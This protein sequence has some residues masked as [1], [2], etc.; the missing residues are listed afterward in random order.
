MKGTITDIEGNGEAGSAKVSYKTDGLYNVTVTLSNPHGSDSKTYSY[1]QI[2][3][4]TGIA[5]VT[6]DELRAY[7]VGDVVYLEFAAAG[8]YNVQ[9][10]NIAGQLV[11]AKAAELT[12]SDRMQVR[13]PMVGAYVLRVFRDGKE[14]KALKLLR[15]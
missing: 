13:L 8:D 14:V 10:Y 2:G 11:A 15:D 7:S 12:S 4:G 5:D 6:A 3:D 9:V 1:I